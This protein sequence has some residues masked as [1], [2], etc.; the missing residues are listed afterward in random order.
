[1][2]IDE[3]KD[4]LT[5]AIKDWLPKTC[6]QPLSEAD[7]RCKIIDFILIDVLGW[8]EPNIRRE[9]FVKESG[10]YIDYLLSTSRSLYVVEAKRSEKMFR[11]PNAKGRRRFKI[12][13]VLAEDKELQEAIFQAQHYAIAK[14]V[15]YCCVTN[16]SQFVFFRSQ[17]EQGLEF[18]S[19]T[20]LAYS[21]IEVVRDNFLEFYSCLSF[22][23]VSQGLHHKVVTAT[24]QSEA[25]EGKFKK[26][27]YA[28]PHSSFRHRNRLFPFIK[29]VVT[30]VFQDLASNG[31]SEDLI[32][33]CYVTSARDSGYDQSLRTLLKD[34]PTFSE[35]KVDPL[36]VNK[37]GAGD[38]DKIVEKGAVDEVVLL[39]GGIGAGKSTFIQ[40]F[41]KVI[42][43]EKIDQE[44]LWAYVNFN[45]YSDA[46]GYLSRWVAEAITIELERDYPDLEFGS[47]PM[48]K[49]AYHSEYER[50]KRGRLAPLF[51]RDRDEFEMAFANEIEKFEEDRIGHLMRLLKAS[52]RKTSRRVFLVFDNAD[53]FEADLQNEVFMLAS[54]IAKEVNCSLIISLREESYWKNKDFGALSAFHSINFHVEAP[55]IQQVIAKRFRYASELLRERKSQLAT[56]GSGITV[57]EALKVFDAI[58]A[59]LLGSGDSI[60]IDFLER[61]SPGEVRRPL[62]QLARFLF[63]GHTNVDAL[64]RGVRNGTVIKIGFHEFLKSIALGDREHFDEAK[65]DIVNLYALDGAHDASN[66]NRLAVLGRLLRSRGVSSAV[67]VGFVPLETIVSDM[68][69]VG[70]QEETT[71]AVVDFLN[72]RRLLESERQA[73]ESIVGASYI[74]ATSA[75]EYY[76]DQLGR[77]FSYMD[78]V[79]PGTLVSSDQTFDII[80]RI[81]RQIRELGTTGVDRVLKLEL[82]FERAEAY[83]Q[84]LLGEAQ[85]HS[86]FASADFLQ[87]SVVELVRALPSII[88]AQR[89]PVLQSARQVLSV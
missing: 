47:F 41:R 4:L 40:R 64:L 83:A 89:D 28:L 76:A 11:I 63:S 58:K 57:D 42:A 68:E 55:R 14:G 30:E 59:A 10:R 85:R 56:E 86:A 72:A 49:Q 33:Q 60:Y 2:T 18:L 54:R 52:A 78:L 65:S 38:F 53:Q 79:I 23:A 67:G 35:L 69:S 44:C 7:T 43:K 19:Q 9:P 32:E 46:P 87:G 66:L 50:L 71:M 12:G 20:A 22:E 62:S 31:A 34:R 3:A 74:R 26:L 37:K 51:N 36:I 1:M 25:L 45:K 80:E 77:Q 61:L 84:Y 16:G 39:L 5:H 81:S 75:A 15:A 82:R 88:N 17:N 21:S 24:E 70:L 13:G 29:E 6:A 48:L 27:S 8:G 73:R